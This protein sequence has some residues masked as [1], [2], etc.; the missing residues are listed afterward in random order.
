MPS[1]SLACR[2]SA[3]SRASR[4]PFSPASLFS[5]G[6]QGVWYDPSDLSTLFQDAAGTIPVTAVEQPV[7]KI[8]DK[9]GRGNHATQTTTTSRPVLSARYNLQTNTENFSSWTNLNSVVIANAAVAPNGLP[10]AS[11]LYPSSSGNFRWVYRLPLGSAAG[12]ALTRSV[13]A[14]ANGKRFFYITLDGDG[15]L[16]KTVFF[17]LINGTLGS[18][19]NGATASIF[20]V[21]NGWYKCTITIGSTVSTDWGLICGPS[22]ANNSLN[23]TA[24]GTSGIYIWGAS[25]VPANQAHLPYQRV[26]TATDYDTAGFPHYLRFDGVDDW[27]VTPSINFTSTD[28]MTVFAGVRKLSDAAGG[29]FAELSMD[30]VTFVGSFAL[31]APSVSGSYRFFSKGTLIQGA[32]TGNFAPAPNT[33]VITGIGNISGDVVSIRRNGALLETNSTDQGADNYGNFPLYIGRHGGTSLP[34]N[35]HLYSLIIR[36]AQSSE[37]QILSAETYCNQKTGAY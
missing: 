20:S 23:V 14:K 3:V 8:L 31:L 28:K 19:A 22:D 11:L 18:V 5:S 9:S 2:L 30:V 16:S 29:V 7:G 25:L 37:A 26:N 10:T 6:E 13:Y 21:G 33:S 24:D 36:G 34:F 4:R 35:G 27:L 17:D 15:A 1:L 32:G 12:G